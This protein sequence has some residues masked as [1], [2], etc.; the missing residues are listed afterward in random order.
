MQDLMT[1]SAVAEWTGLSEV[2][3]R[4]WRTEGKGP[5]FVRLGRAV[6]YRREDIAAFVELRTYKSTS[7]ADVSSQTEARK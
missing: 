7:E 3:L 4:R 1:T 6:R 5:S 2:T